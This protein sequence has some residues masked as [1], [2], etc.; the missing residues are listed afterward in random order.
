MFYRTFG[1]YLRLLLFGTAL[2]ALGF[3]PA[4]EVLLTVLATADLHGNTSQIEK[5]IAPAVAAARKLDPQ[6]IYIDAGDAA[7][8]TLAVNLA[9]GGNVLALLASAGCDIFVPGNHE[10]EYGFEIFKKLLKSFPNTVLAANL[11]APEL[12]KSYQPWVIKNVKGVKIAFIGMMLKDMT[13]AFPVDEKRFNT[14]AYSAILRK[15]VDAV[16]RAGAEVIV[17]IQHAGKY[18]AGQNIYELLAKFPEIDLVIGAHTHRADAGSSAVDAWY[19]QPPARGSKLLKAVI[20]FDKRLRRVK[21]I[22]S[23]LLDLPWF[24]TPYP[25]QAYEKVDK[26]NHDDP[27]FPARIIA[28]KVK[29]HWAIYAVESRNKL[30]EL[31][32][33]PAPDLLAYYRVFPYYDRIITVEVSGGEL[34]EIVREYLA[35]CRK[36]KMFLA[37]SGFSFSSSRGKLRTIHDLERSKVRTLA[38][39]A[40]AAAGAG[41]QLPGIRRIL[42]NK[43]NHRQA[44]NAPG[45]LQLITNK[46]SY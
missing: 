24:D 28:G 40:Y 6:T 21:N 20:R 36:R 19:V 31:L 27:N 9:Q 43:I 3:L 11:H 13:T 35:F 10:L 39:S 22:E 38:I 12:E 41:G 37:V 26:T 44:E 29:S 23:S 34:Y 5:A 7:Q 16:I 33:D 8:G 2:L 46:G 4:G 18:S 25:A 32:R 14:F 45:I 30:M 1:G 42:K 15:N 17:L